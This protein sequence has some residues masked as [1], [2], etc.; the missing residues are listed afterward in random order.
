MSYIKICYIFNEKLKDK[1]ITDKKYHKFRDH[2]HY[3]GEYRSSTHSTCNLKYSV[4]K[5]IY[6]DFHNVSNYDYPSIIKE[7]A[8]E[9][10]GKL[11]CLGENTVKHII[12]SVTLEVPR[13]DTNG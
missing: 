7:L 9:C 10:E 8:K 2:C 12:F 6:I 1:Y 13:I 5:E 3:R 4:F 11:N